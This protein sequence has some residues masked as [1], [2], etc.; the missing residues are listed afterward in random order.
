MKKIAALLL[1]VLMITAVALADLEWPA[2]ANEGQRQLQAWVERANAALTTLSEGQIDMRYE[3]YPA[4]ASLGM[5]G[6]DTP[7]MVEM[8]FT[9]AEEG[10]LSL[11][12]RVADADRFARIAAAC[13]HAVSPAG[14]PIDQASQVTRAYAATA[15]ADPYTSFSEEVNTLQGSQPRAYFAY[16]PDQYADGRNWLQMTLIF[17]RPGSEGGL[18]VVPATPTPVDDI[19]EDD[20]LQGYFSQDNY[21]HLEVFTTATPEPDSAAM[22]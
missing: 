5:D 21:S 2:P 3:L 13:I 14:T 7:E 11:Q 16:Y 9:L 6:A 8:Y 15:K 4:F 17:P 1:S 12:L 19:V 18:F 20:E 22:E 10:I